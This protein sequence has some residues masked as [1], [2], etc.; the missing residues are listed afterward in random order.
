MNNRNKIKPVGD[1]RILN[2]VV[3]CS[4]CGE[5][6]QID[7]VWDY[8]F[9]ADTGKRAFIYQI[10]CPSRKFWNFLG[11]HEKYEIDD[12]GIRHDY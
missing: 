2:R 8:W 4:G 12:L 11:T 1:P 10:K 6:L 7:T 9:H 3:Y 5:K